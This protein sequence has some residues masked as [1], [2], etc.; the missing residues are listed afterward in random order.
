[1]MERYLVVI[2]TVLV[3]TQL[4]R[5]MQNFVNLHRQNKLLNAQLKE[6]SEITD[7]DIKR[8]KE[9]DRLLLKYLRNKSYFE[10]DDMK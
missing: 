3:A 5:I 7:D 8:R 1:M 9:I 10:Y 4:I 2:T 6:L